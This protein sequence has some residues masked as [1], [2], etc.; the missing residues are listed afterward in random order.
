MTDV[1]ANSLFADLVT[2]RQSVKP[3]LFR[4]W[5][6]FEFTFLSSVEAQQLRS[7]N[8]NS[9]NRFG[10]LRTGSFGF[11]WVQSKRMHSRAYGL[12]SKVR[13]IW[14]KAVRRASTFG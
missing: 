12:R 13:C 14:K 4:H 11:K 9:S 1:M 10:A 6:R 2:P 7:K 5:F 8:N 3:K